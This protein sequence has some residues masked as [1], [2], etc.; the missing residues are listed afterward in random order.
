MLRFLS[1]LVEKCKNDRFGA[2]VCPVSC[3]F[4]ATPLSSFPCVHSCGGSRSHLSLHTP[5][6]NI[7]GLG[8]FLGLFPG[9]GWV[10]EEEKMVT[11]MGTSG[12]LF[13]SITAKES[14]FPGPS[15]WVTSS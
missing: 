1:W 4:P 13:I 14:D 6:M 2:L 3:L 7:Q 10:R 8:V 12:G 11:R 9:C 5:R 15:S